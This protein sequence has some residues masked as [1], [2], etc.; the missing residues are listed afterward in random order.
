M[1]TVDRS[2]KAPQPGL[3]AAR[4]VAPPQPQS[5]SCARSYVRVGSI[6]TL[7]TTSGSVRC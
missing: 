7:L 2:E 1:D 6:A 3:L 5:K 4:A